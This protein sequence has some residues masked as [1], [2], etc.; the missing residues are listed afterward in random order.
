MDPARL[1]L[2][3]FEDLADVAVLPVCDAEVPPRVEYALTELG[4]T[5]A[6]PVRALAN[7]ASDNQDAIP[8][9]R[10]AYDETGKQQADG[11]PVRA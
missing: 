7:W 11:V 8:A 4:H 1:L 3:D 5:L 2:M 6:E 9:H 10:N